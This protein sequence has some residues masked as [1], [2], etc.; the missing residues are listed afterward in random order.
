MET[1]AGRWNEHAVGITDLVVADDLRRQGLAEFLLTQ[2][3]R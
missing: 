3:L 2:I 1:Y